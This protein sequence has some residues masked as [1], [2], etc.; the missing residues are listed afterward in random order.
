MRKKLI[1]MIGCFAVV[2]MAFAL[3]KRYFI[4]DKPLKSL[5]LEEIAAV[6]VELLPPDRSVRLTAEQI[7]ALLPLLRGVVTFERDDTY[8]DYCGQAVIFTIS[9]QDGTA[10]RVMAYNPFI[11]LDGAGYRCKYSPCEA[12]NQFANDLIR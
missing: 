9:K 2:L 4:G 6:E 3:C 11:V 8:R 10:V 1:I 12:L 5:N 7:E